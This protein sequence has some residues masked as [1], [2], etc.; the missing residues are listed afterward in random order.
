LLT[1]GLPPSSFDV[2]TTT[3]NMTSKLLH[4]RVDVAASTPNAIT[5]L[6]AHEGASYD[7]VRKVFRISRAGYYFAFNQQ[8]ETGI[9]ERL[10]RAFSEVASAGYVKE[11]IERY[12]LQDVEP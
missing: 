8:T 11:A 3:A 9:S 1:L 6:L 4:R 2:S 12:G 10:A 7:T 5:T